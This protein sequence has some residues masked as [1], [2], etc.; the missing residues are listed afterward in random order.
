MAK[1]YVVMAEEGERDIFYTHGDHLGSACWITSFDGK[2]IQYMHYLPYGQL[3]ANQTPYGYD[4]RYKFTGKE[5]D[6]QTPF[7]S[8]APEVS[9]P[10][11]DNIRKWLSVDPLA[12]KYPNISPYAYCNWNPVKYVDPDGRDWY[13]ADGEIKW[14]EL[15]SQQA[16]DEAKLA[17]KYLGEAAVIFEGNENECWGTDNTLTGKNANPAM[18]TIYG[19]NG[20]D[21]I[22]NYL[23]M[24]IPQSDSYSTLNAGE[25]KLF[26]QDMATSI[27]GEKGA[28]AHNPPIPPALTYRITKSDGN[29][30][31]DGR[32]K[33]TTKAMYSVF[34]HRTDWNGKANHS[35]K[36]C[37]IIDGRQWR[38]VE[39]QLKKSSNIFLRINR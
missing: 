34:L 28:L 4:E 37:M 2:P 22:Q 38:N 18:V 36:G 9:R 39:T 1:K 23:G 15:K 7:D 10:I 11:T 32:I 20:K 17:G 25:Y 24:T 26:Y 29:A 27:Y 6:A 13:E 33:G 30:I 14:T 31:L 21:D 5:R 3:L 35:S 8:F 19:V 16:M 12:D